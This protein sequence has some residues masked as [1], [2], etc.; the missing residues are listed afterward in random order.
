MVLIFPSQQS[1]R[2][3]RSESGFGLAVKV[4]QSGVRLSNGLAFVCRCVSAAPESLV[5]ALFAQFL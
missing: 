4:T 5:A 1:T 3:S 2:L